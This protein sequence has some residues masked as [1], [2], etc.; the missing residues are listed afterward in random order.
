MRVCM[1]VCVCLVSL[2]SCL[3]VW[4]C[5]QFVC[6]CRQSLCLYVLTL[7]CMFEG[8]VVCLCV[9]FACMFMSLLPSR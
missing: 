5:V 9:S 8:V 2:H 7:G 6:G 3:C 1:F 4:L